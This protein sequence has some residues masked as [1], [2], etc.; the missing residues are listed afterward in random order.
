M[1][2]LF[3]MAYDL[4]VDIR[5]LRAGRADFACYLLCKRPEG[6]TLY[7][8]YSNFGWLDP[9]FGWWLLEFEDIPTEPFRITG[10]TPD[11]DQYR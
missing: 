1:V 5:L 11:P 6:A 7:Q 2:P 3:L 9:E 10:Q 4:T 8:P